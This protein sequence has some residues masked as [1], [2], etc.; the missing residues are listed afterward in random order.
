MEA[1]C[2]RTRALS[3]AARSSAIGSRC[4][5]L[6]AMNRVTHRSDGTVSSRGAATPGVFAGPRE[7]PRA[8]CATAGSAPDAGVL[9]RGTRLGVVASTRRAEDDSRIAV[10]SSGSETRGRSARRDARSRLNV[11]VNVRDMGAKN[12]PRR[13][14]ARRPSRGAPS[15]LRRG[16]GFL[17]SLLGPNRACV[18]FFQQSR[19]PLLQFQR[20]AFLFFFAAPEPPPNAFAFSFLSFAFSALDILLLE[21]ICFFSTSL[22]CFCRRW[23]REPALSFF[24]RKYA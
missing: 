11:G 4:T 24:S 13:A 18:F 5:H 6:N 23:S 20:P 10:A 19:R 9:G 14:G 17:P 16:R 7:G 22:A 15:V 1:V 8:R 21:T 3:C 2:A 12:A